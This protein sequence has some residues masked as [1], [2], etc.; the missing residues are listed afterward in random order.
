LPATPQE[1]PAP[2]GEELL[3]RGVAFFPESAQ[4]P[5]HFIHHVTSVDLSALK[6]AETLKDVMAYRVDRNTLDD[7]LAINFLSK[8]K[9]LPDAAL[10]ADNE[11]RDAIIGFRKLY[12]KEDEYEQLRILSEINWSAKLVFVATLASNLQ[13]QIDKAEINPLK[14]PSD[15]SIARPAQ[16]ISKASMMAPLDDS[17]MMD[18]VANFNKLSDFSTSNLRLNWSDDGEVFVTQRRKGRDYDG[19]DYK[20]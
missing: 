3:A 1:P 18:V 4:N 10:P 7:L 16:F 6:T 2:T 19:P 13:L 5:Q 14:V 11:T 12:F 9:T 8:S 17:M 15:D 20:Y